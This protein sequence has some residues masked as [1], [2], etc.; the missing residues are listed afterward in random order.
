[1]DP[2]GMRRSLGENMGN[3]QCEVTERDAGLLKVTRGYMLDAG[4]LK[5]T[6]G[7]MLDAGL[8]KEYMQSGNA[9]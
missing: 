9:S 3:R 7:Y 2:C 4:L 6:R 1:M 8:L 5:V